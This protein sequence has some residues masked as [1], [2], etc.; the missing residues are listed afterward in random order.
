[1]VYPAKPA[2]VRRRVLRLR[3]QGWSYTQIR[4]EVDIGLATLTT[5]LAPLGGVIRKDMLAPTPWP[6]R[7]PPCPPTCGGR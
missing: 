2:H 6:A 3:A 1:M 4:A 7:S 5:M